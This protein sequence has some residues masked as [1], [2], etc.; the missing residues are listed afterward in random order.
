MTSMTAG[1]YSLHRYGRL[2][3]AIDCEDCNRK[4]ANLT[5]NKSGG[6][7]LDRIEEH[8]QRHHAKPADTGTPM[9]GAAT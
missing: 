2:H 7:L 5:P 8:E 6:E 1:R 4:I 9:R 3:F